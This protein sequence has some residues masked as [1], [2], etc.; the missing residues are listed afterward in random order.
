MYF[1]D[2]GDFQIVGSSPEILVRAEQGEV[3][4]RPIAGT[5]KRGQNPEEDQALAE[6]LLADPKEMAEHL[7]LIDLGR[8]DLGRIAQPGTVEVTESMLIER[9]SH[10][11]HIV[12]N[13]KGRAQTDL[14]AM[15]ALRATLPGRHIEWC[16]E[17]HGHANYRSFRVGQAWRLWWCSGLYFLGG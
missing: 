11:M 4:V 1:L 3:T 2:M 8:N 15:D 10:V 16:T 14:T 13:V 7:M 9:Y 6:E 5:R 17:G 12:S